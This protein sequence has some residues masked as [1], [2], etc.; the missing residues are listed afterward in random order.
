MEE[1]KNTN[2][3]CTMRRHPFALASFESLNSSLKWSLAWKSSAL[4]SSLTIK[5]GS[6]SMR[7][8][9]SV[10][11]KVFESLCKKAASPNDPT[12]LNLSGPSTSKSISSRH[13]GELSTV[14]VDL[15]GLFFVLAALPSLPACA[16]AACA[17]AAAASWRAVGRYRVLPNGNPKKKLGRESGKLHCPGCSQTCAFGKRLANGPAKALCSSPREPSTMCFTGPC[18]LSSALIMATYSPVGAPGLC[19]HSPP[20]RSLITVPRTG[21]FT[22]TTP[23]SWSWVH[24]DLGTTVVS[25]VARRLVEPARGN[26]LNAIT[27]RPNI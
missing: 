3:N 8:T 5:G 15:D 4:G 26:K 16:A 27:P 1:G 17:A 2:P 24:T 23:C 12:A 11:S 7:T 13:G 6:A 10:T 22:F 9:Q 25:T 21:T 19:T 14:F 20:A 18:T